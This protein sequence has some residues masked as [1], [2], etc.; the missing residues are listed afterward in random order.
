[1]VCVFIQINNELCV[2]CAYCAMVCP[3]GC[4]EVKGVS[5]FKEHSC[6]KCLKCVRSCP[7]RA[8][9]PQWIG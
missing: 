2:G 4:F 3:V 9:T 6:V 8:I 5:K 7:V 1:M